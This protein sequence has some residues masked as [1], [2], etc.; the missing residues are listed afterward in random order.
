[1]TVTRLLRDLDSRELTEWH[2]FF[3]LQ[4]QETH[5]ANVEADL[6]KVFGKPKQ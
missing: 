5:T 3:L 2:A 6:R 1:M 4:R